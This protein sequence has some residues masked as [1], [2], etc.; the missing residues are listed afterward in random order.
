MYRI[1]D[2]ET[3]NLIKYEM[4]ARDRIASPLTIGRGGVVLGVRNR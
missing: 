4:R 1:S 3:L 2:I